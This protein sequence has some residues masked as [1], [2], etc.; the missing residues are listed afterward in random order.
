MQFHVDQDSGSTISGWVVPDNPSAVPQLLVSINGGQTVSVKAGHMRPD[1]KALGLHRTG[2][3]G[4]GID[5][6]NCPG[7]TAAPSVRIW[8]KESQALVY[9][10]FDPAHHIELKVLYYELSVMPQTRLTA[11]LQRHFAM[12]YE[13]VERYSFDTL[14]AIINNQSGK[15]IYLGGRP[16][17]KRYQHLL[18]DRGF[19]AVT[20]LRDPYEEMAERLLFARYASR[21]STPRHL[22]RHLGGLAALVE[23]ASA[24]DVS[25]EQATTVA[26]KTLTPEHE[27]VLA[28]P[29]VRALA[30]DFDEPAERKHVG[31]ALDNLASMNLVGLRQ[32][33][34][35]FKSMLQELLGADLV[36][37]AEP[38]AVSLVP[39]IAEKLARID[40]V[41]SLLS[42][43]VLLY[44]LARDAIRK[45]VAIT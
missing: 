44:N 38:V 25:S 10:R 33:F 41:K 39:Q 19:T 24:F 15:S 2:L 26:F 8:E 42:F 20:M 27:R 36:G 13:A 30:C 18:A 9:G 1:I 28:N 29:F 35:T 16:H 37:D 5:E 6:R 31:I 3:V 34:D 32:R 14:Y 7:L 12:P 22:L 23:L 40:K 45:A 43:D 21:P 4:F 17:F 11:N